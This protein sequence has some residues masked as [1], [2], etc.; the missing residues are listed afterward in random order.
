MIE[1]AAGNG[2]SWWWAS[3]IRTK[4]SK[5]LEQS[6]Q[7]ME[8]KVEHVLNLIQKDGD[9]FAR[10]AEMYYRHRP[11]LISFVEETVRAY[12]ALAER[13]DKLSTELQK[14][15]TTIAAICPEKVMYDD[16]DD[17][18]ADSPSK[19]PK[20]T[21]QNTTK[22]PKNS[23]MPRKTVKG[24]LK[25][26]S[27]SIQ[28]TKTTKTDRSDDV[29]RSGLT[30][31]EALEEIN[32]LQKEIV[33]MQT[34]KEFMKGSYESSLAQYWDTESKITEHQQKVC[35]LQDEFQVS[36]IIEEDD[37]RTLMVEGALKSCEET[38]DNLQKTQ[39][40]SSQEAKQKLKS[41][42]NNE[43]KDA[44]EKSKSNVPNQDDQNETKECFES[45]SK[46]PQ[47]DEEMADTIEK[48]VN[49]V[50]SLE[51]SVS[52]QTALINMLRAEADD[53]Q[54]QIRKSE[55]NKAAL[56]VGVPILIKIRK[57]LEEKSNGMQDLDQNVN[58][59]NKSLKTL[60]SEALHN[61]ELLSEKIE[62]VKM[63]GESEEPID[64]SANT[65]ILSPQDEDKKV[66]EVKD[67]VLES[68]DDINLREMLS[69][70]E[71]KEK[72]LLEEYI[73]ILRN[74]KDTKK[75]LAEEEERNQGALSP[76][77]GHARK[78]NSEIVKRDNEIRLLKQKLKLLQETFGKDKVDIP[79]EEKEGVTSLDEPQPVSAIQEKLRT[80]I[81]AILD[82]N[83]DFWFKFGAMFY[84]VHKFTKQVQ[85]LQE[86]AKKV[87]ANGLMNKSS[88]SMFTTDLISN[89]RPIYKHLK[90]INNELTSWLERSTLLKDEL[91]MR[92][93]SLSN[94][95]EEITRALRESLKEE[96][97][98]FGSLVAAKFQGEIL[99]IKQENNKVKDE[100]QAGL[101]HATALKHEI[102][103][104]LARL[105]Q[106]FGLADI[107]NQPH[108]KSTRRS[109][110][111]LR[112]FLFGGKS[113]KPKLSLFACFG[114]HK[115][116]SVYKG[117]RM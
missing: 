44:D 43:E 61:L 42:K 66:I 38:L 46:N 80:D 48:L 54:T 93:L 105:E 94:I 108:Q 117:G 81:D 8:E 21:S 14:A 25:N 101:D 5:W 96:E 24:L 49:K 103:M 85:D 88:T 6:L 115:K 33:G 41:L 106:E 97:I 87:K 2:Y 79:S 15:N 63:K 18:Y 20:N 23:K 78:L 31:D 70:F 50:I 13:Y 111:P 39:E 56:I 75:K 26:A 11:E 32:K 86:M 51:S 12:R 90:E 83:L 64:E 110:I 55:D 29:L 112:S 67:C 3:H 52:S 91:Q 100:L 22:M 84:Q 40:K 116:S 72:I 7:D 92:C 77:T 74:Y 71:E 10:R 107:P 16:Y 102:Q 113:K 34:M 65:K 58:N 4:Q 35:S 76:V 30:K 109:R 17:D 60:F 95:Q 37:A 53:L 62:S 69:G 27:K 68:E 19:M 9:S 104:T 45:L 114:H 99:N 57:S 98:K 89:I 82:E 73:T 47:T 1:K 36:R 59:E 28:G